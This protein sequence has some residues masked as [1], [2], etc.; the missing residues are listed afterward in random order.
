MQG[1]ITHKGGDRYEVRI[2]LG[3]GPD[4]RRRQLS[5]SVRGTRADA[6]ALCARLLVQHDRTNLDGHDATMGQ[7]VERW[8]AMA[9]PSLSPTTANDYRS[10][11]TKYVVPE[12]G[13]VPVRQ[14]RAATLDHWYTRLRQSGVGTARIRR[15]HQVVANALAQAVR[16]EWIPV[17]PAKSAS[18]PPVA[19][20]KA[21]KPPSL[22]D[23]AHLFAEAERADPEFALFLRL[24]LSLGARRGE[25]CGLRW[26]DIDLDDHTIHIQRA[27][28]APKAGVQIKTTKTGAGRRVTVPQVVA[29]D[30]RAHRRRCQ[31]RALA[32]GLRL[33]DD[34]WVFS[35]DPDSGSP[36][37]PD[38]VTHRFDRL[39]KA[40]GLEHVTLREFRH[41]HATQLIAAGVD[42]STVSNRLG[43]ARKSTTLDRYADWLPAADRGAADVMDRLLGGG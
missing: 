23:A 27:V 7:L 13:L 11:I 5:R 16:W 8:Y 20:R 9:S 35:L 34:A 17:N 22:D 19:A 43:H 31:E 2:N 10:V 18:P 26:D 3:R 24:S 4:G 33:A 30:L 25:I 38:L 6:E 28:V 39:R 1:S 21:I 36:W 37:R 12:L 42:I 14:I 40:A 41:A 15:I 32:V 29:A